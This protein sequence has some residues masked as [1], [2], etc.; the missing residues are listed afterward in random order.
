MRMA[1]FFKLVL[2]TLSPQN[3]TLIVNGGV[4][5]TASSL[6]DL[7]IQT[8]DVDTTGYQMKIWGDLVGNP[9]EATASWQ[10]FESAPQ[11]TL[12]DGDG[13]KKIYVKLRDDVLN[14]SAIVS[15]TIEVDTTVP[16]VTL[17]SGPDIRRVSYNAPKD[18]VNFSWRAD[19]DI[20]QWKVCVV[21][22]EADAH[23]VGAIIPM[24]NGSTEL[25]GGE[26]TANTSV[27]AVLKV[28]DMVEASSGDGEKIIKV[29]VKT[30]SGVW[31]A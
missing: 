28:R 13:L 24:T 18:T 12:S 1:S 29:F 27:A 20:V 4:S 25:T 2:D 30:V 10:T 3:V 17:V 31:S 11:V 16:V 9:T 6:A 21:S 23:N 22:N 5:I 26:V 19:I 7:L 8:A 15:A 14:E